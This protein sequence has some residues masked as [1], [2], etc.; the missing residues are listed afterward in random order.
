ML[1]L[2]GREDEEINLA[3][4]AGQKLNAQPRPVP[5]RFCFHVVSTLCLPPLQG[6]SGWR[7]PG[8]NPRVEPRG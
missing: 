6:A 3:P 2:K 1:A 4:I 8:L 7:F 5:I